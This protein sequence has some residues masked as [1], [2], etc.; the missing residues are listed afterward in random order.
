MASKRATD[1][2]TDTSRT[3]TAGTQAAECSM[4]TPCCDWSTDKQ[5]PVS[6]RGSASASAISKRFADG[7]ASVAPGRDLVRE[8]LDCKKRQDCVSYKVHDVVAD[9]PNLLHRYAASENTSLTV[10]FEC[11]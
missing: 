3:Y 5:L 11:R 2:L 4:S 1:G 10:I 7:V 9:E 6:G 8:L